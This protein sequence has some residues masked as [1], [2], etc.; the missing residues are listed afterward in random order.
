MQYLR[1]ATGNLKSKPG[2]LQS[3]EKR[4]RR[5]STA[6]VPRHCT[7]LAHVFWGDEGHQ[8]DHPKEEK[9]LEDDERNSVCEDLADAV[10]QYR[11]KQANHPEAVHAQYLEGHK[12]QEASFASLCLPLTLAVLVHLDHGIGVKQASKEKHDGGN[13]HPAREVHGHANGLLPEDV[14]D[15]VLVGIV[16]SCKPCHDRNDK[17]QEDAAPHLEQGLLQQ[18]LRHRSAHHGYMA[19]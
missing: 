17:S 2:R 6:M 13:L 19:K 15:L 4:P 12:C 3:L 7:N 9:E 14:R 1:Q 5:L 8:K 11:A 16:V 10:V 18:K